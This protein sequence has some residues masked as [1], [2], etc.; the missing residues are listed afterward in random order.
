MKP[1]KYLILA[2][3]IAGLARAALAGG[4]EQAGALYRINGEIEAKIQ[5]Q[6]LDRML[7][8]GK[9]FVFLETRAELKTSAEEESKEGVGEVHVKL[10]PGAAGSEAAAGAN[11]NGEKTAKD[12]MSEQSSR[13]SKKSDEKKN[14]MGL[15]VGSMQARILHDASLSQE[16]LKAVKEALAALYPGKIKPDEIVFVPAAFAPAP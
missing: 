12:K 6:V 10:P 5:S 4:E 15:T 8:A 7:G 2:T 16:K 1:G 3:L 14:I 11:K 9:A 13:Q